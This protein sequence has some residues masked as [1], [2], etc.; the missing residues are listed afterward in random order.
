MI[1]D[2]GFRAAWWLKNPHAQT[3]WPALRRRPREVALRRERVTLPDGDFVDLDYAPTGPGP[4]VLLLHGLEGDP[5]SVYARA[6]LA[7]FS[8][9][10][11]VAVRMFHRSCSGELNRRAQLYHSGFTDDAVVVMNLLRARYPGRPLALVGVSLGG[12]VALNL[13]GRPGAAEGLQYMPEAVVAISVPFEL[14]ACARRI[15]RGWSRVYQRRLLASMQAK[16]AAKRAGGTLTG[17][18]PAV[19]PDRA[20]QAE[21]FFEFDDAFTAPLHG[22]SGAEEYYRVCSA[23]QYLGRIQTPTVV[24]QAIDDPF[25]TPE[26]LPSAAELAP[27]V[28]LECSARGGHVGFVGGRTP[29]RATYWLEPK[30]VA[31]LRRMLG[32]T[33]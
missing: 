6:M 22:F 12:S 33:V 1:V 30:V 15:D 27:A 18:P 25:M 14:A 16:V 2:S 11:H 32:S 3:V 29:G 9:A 8:D 20:L 7:A 26:A 13:V 17:A 19:D 5:G 23:R 21:N 10:G 28:T 4:V 24:V 31:T